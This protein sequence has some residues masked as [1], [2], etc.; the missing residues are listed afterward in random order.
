M[1]SGHGY[2]TECYIYVVATNETDMSVRIRLPCSEALMCVFSSTK[3]APM[4]VVTLGAQLDSVL[5]P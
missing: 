2:L 5:Q 3:A 1:T 4:S